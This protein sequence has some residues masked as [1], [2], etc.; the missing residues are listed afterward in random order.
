MSIGSAIF[1]AA[2]VFAILYL[3]KIT[4]DRWNWRRIMRRTL[5]A[6]G[7]VVTVTALALTGVF[8][9]EKLGSRPQTQ[10]GYA[11]LRLGMTMAE[12]EYVKGSPQYAM[13]K[14]EKQTSPK[15]TIWKPTKD[16]KDNEQIEDYTA[17]EYPGDDDTRV[18]VNFD[19]KTKLVIQ[20]ACFSHTNMKCPTLLGIH[21]GMN[22]TSVIERLGK[23]SQEKI[24]GVVQEI[25]YEHIGAWFRLEKTKVYMLGVMNVTKAPPCKNGAQTCN[26]WDR[27]WEP[28]AIEAR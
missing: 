20:I 28:H 15:W 23:P 4:R 8:V 6:T 18:D 17:W 22:E 19:V 16:L 13:E 11:D 2:L 3:Y 26:P 24:Q 9:N 25:A 10:T 21:D 7:W 27:D 14:S 5:V 12:V 1:L